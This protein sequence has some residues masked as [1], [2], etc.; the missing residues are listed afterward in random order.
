MVQAFD[1]TKPWEITPVM[2]GGSGEPQEMSEEKSKTV[3]TQV[4]PFPLLDYRKKGTKLKLLSSEKVKDKDAYHLK[5]SPK[6]GAESEI[7]IDVSSGLMSKLKTIQ[8]GQDVEIVFSNYKEIEGINFAMSMESS[9]PVAGIITIET[10]SVK[11]NT[12]ID[13]LIFKMPIKN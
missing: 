13:E 3:I 2:M 8:N 4:D 11:L 1:G 9:N 6:A 12:P 7:W 5:I 10:K